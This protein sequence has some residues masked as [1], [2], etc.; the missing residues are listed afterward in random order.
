MVISSAILCLYN[1][2][3]IALHVRNGYK[4][5]NVLVKGFGVK[6]NLSLSFCS[7]LS[8]SVCSSSVLTTKIEVKNRAYC[9]LTQDLKNFCSKISSWYFLSRLKFFLFF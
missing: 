3:L 2:G 5:T 8:C 1:I 6:F 9:R 4:G 7:L